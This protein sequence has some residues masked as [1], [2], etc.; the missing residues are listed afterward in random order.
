MMPMIQALSLPRPMLRFQNVSHVGLFTI[1]RTRRVHQSIFT[2]R[3]QP[4]KPICCV[5]LDLSKA[6][7]HAP[8]HKLAGFARIVLLQMLLVP[9][10]TRGQPCVAM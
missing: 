8:A 5:T 4:V 10:T 2:Q 3:L 6:M 7:L 9:F 1:L